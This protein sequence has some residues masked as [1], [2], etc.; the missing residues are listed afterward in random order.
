MK[1]S[2]FFPVFFVSSCCPDEFPV[3]DVEVFARMRPLMD[4][5]LQVVDPRRLFDAVEI[6]IQTLWGRDDLKSY[7]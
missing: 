6:I 4:N 7:F 3:D 2:S 1:L 5:L